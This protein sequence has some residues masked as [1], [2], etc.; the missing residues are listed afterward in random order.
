MKEYAIAP[1]PA[2]LFFSSKRLRSRIASCFQLLDVSQIL[3]A[4]AGFLVGDEMVA[5]DYKNRDAAKS[6]VQAIWPG[7]RKFHTVYRRNY[8]DPNR[9]HANLED[10]PGFAE[11]VLVE[12]AERRAKLRQGL[13]DS[14]SI[15]GIR[16]NPNV[17]ILRINILDASRIVG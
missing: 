8:V 11:I 9:R 13:Q 5:G 16:A 15:L 14:L 4:R 10:S 17:N 6:C 7:V 3:Q 2:G 1:E 12:I